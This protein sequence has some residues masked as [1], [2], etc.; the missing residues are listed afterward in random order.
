[1]HVKEM[2]LRE[3]LTV[4]K[5]KKTNKHGLEDISKRLNNRIC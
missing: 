2:E 3:K 4:S 5:E 1:M